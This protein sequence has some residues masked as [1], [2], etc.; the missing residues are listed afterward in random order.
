MAST[1]L[2]RVQGAGMFTTTAASGTSVASGTISPTNIS[3]L[4][5][6]SVIFP[7]GDVRSVTAVSG[8]TITCGGVVTNIKG[9]KG[10]T[11]AM[12][13]QGPQG[14]AAT[15]DQILN[16]VYPVGSIYMSVN[17]VSPQTFIGGTWVAWGAGRVPV[18]VDTTDSN[19]NTVEK[20]GGVETVKLTTSQ[21]PSHYHNIANALP[22]TSY[23]NN[24]GLNY[25]ETIA[26]GCFGRS[27][28]SNNFGSTNSGSRKTN[29]LGNFKH[30]HTCE[31]TGEGAAHNNLQPYIT[32]YMW[33][34]TA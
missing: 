10:D 23:V 19:F 16:L 30:T 9:E 4:V 24:V 33:K 34:R 3:P 14:P 2:G 5:G 17:N 27:Q 15:T 18:S 1:N 11:G 22:S 7:N 20:T 6:D 12:G 26:G 21:M 25:S 8:G 13:P 28:S 32:C 29:I 31:T